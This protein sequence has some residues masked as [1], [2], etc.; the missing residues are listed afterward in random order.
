MMASEVRV[1]C[2]HCYSRVSLLPSD[3]PGAEPVLR[4]GRGS[5]ECM[6]GVV[7]KLMPT[8]EVDC[9]DESCGY[10]EPHRHGFA[11]GRTCRGCGRG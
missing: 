4:D 10:Q 6:P 5:R 2:Q 7:H 9:H 11:C 1:S 8:A 3:D